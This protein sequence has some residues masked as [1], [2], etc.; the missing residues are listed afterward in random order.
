MRSAFAALRVRNYRLFAVASLIPYIGI[1]AQRVSQDW[2]IVAMGG[3]PAALGIATGLQFL[4]LL[5]FST[6]VG[7]V[8]DRVPKRAMLYITQIVMGGSS[9]FLGALAMFGVVELWHV[10]TVAFVFGVGSAFDRPT[11]LS[12]INE[13]VDESL[14]PSGIGLNS[15]SLN[16]S[17]AVGPAVAGLSIALLGSS[18]F[19]TGVVIALNGMTFLIGMVLLAR[20]NVSELYS[21]DRLLRARG[22]IREALRYVADDR[23]TLLILLVI[24]IVGTFGLNYQLTIALIATQVYE[25][26]AGELGILGA[27]MAVGSLGGSLNA[28]RS[29]SVHS[30]RFVATALTFGVITAM[31]GL[32][33][34]FHSFMLFLLVCGFSAMTLTVRATTT[35]QMRTAPQMRGRVMSLYVL[36]LMGGTPIGAPLLGWVAARYGARWTL[37]GGG[38]LTL[39]GVGCSSVVVRFLART[40]TT[41]RRSVGVEDGRTPEPDY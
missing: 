32:M 31:A 38:L 19:D 23:P 27:A 39:A 11:R 2:L 26:G 34:T 17:R 35:I 15:A 25:V 8:A 16:L 5:L 13:V 9:C 36:V 37:I 20:I 10:Y 29:A 6:V 22:Q 3:G 12:F 18:V 30:G 7:L 4:P 33:P 1:W 41:P 21:S 40:R 28:V 24:L 14:A